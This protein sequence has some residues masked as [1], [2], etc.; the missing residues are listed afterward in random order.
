MKTRDE[1]FNE[2][3][4]MMSELFEIPVAEIKPDSHFVDDLNLDSIDAIDL[5][6]HFQSVIG[7]RLDPHDFK[8]VRKVSD[9]VDAAEKILVHQSSSNE[10]IG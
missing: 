1:I 7:Q 9:V 6:A 5:I 2:L 10:S 3:A 4:S 8:M